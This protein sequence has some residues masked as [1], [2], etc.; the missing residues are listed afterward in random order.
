MLFISGFAL[1]IAGMVQKFSYKPD[2][3]LNEI[4]GIWDTP[5]PRYFYASFTYKN[6]WAAFSLLVVAM[7]LG[8]YFKSLQTL[9]NSLSKR[10]YSIFYLSGSVVIIATISHCGSRSGVLII[11]MFIF[12]LCLVLV[13]KFLKI[14]S[15]LTLSRLMLLLLS[16]L[17]GGLF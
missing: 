4:W 7:G 14:F 3:N 1:G 2:S 15:G 10:F 8:L 6:H 17:L 12:L 9:S 16:F 13:R 11:I 5:E